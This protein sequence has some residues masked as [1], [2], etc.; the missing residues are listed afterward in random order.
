M[1]KQTKIVKEEN[2]KKKSLIPLVL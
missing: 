2:S 1:D